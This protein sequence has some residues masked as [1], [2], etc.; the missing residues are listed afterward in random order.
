MDVKFFKCMHCGNVAI[1]VFDQGV[2][3]SCCGE[4]MAEH[5]ARLQD[6]KVVC[7]HCFRPYDR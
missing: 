3:M 7:L 5:M 6:G 1:K 2:P 4:A